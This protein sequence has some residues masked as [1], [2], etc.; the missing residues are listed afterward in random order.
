MGLGLELS[1]RCAEV[2]K[3]DEKGRG[4]AAW[5]LLR[6]YEAGVSFPELTPERVRVY[7]G[8]SIPFSVFRHGYLATQRH[9]EIF[10]EAFLKELFRAWRDEVF[11]IDRLE[12]FFVR[13]GQVAV[14]ID[15]WRRATCTS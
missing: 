13:I 4:R 8:L 5:D 11:Q 15:K 10:G 9:G 2:V 7:A 14:L 6:C 3:T 1:R 12:L